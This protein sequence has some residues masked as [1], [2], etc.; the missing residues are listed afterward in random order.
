LTPAKFNQRT[1]FAFVCPITGQAKGYPFEVAI[2]KGL[3]VYGVILVDQL[4]A[5]DWEARGAVKLGECPQPLV[6]LVD[7]RIKTILGYAVP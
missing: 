5:K 3:P 1:K 2:P 6:A 4:G 7:V